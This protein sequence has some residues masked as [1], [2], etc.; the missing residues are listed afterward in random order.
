MTKLG[1]ELESID[2]TFS[3]VIPQIHKDMIVL[4]TVSRRFKETHYKTG[5]RM[6]VYISRK[7]T[8]A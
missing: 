4:K 7:P 3:T 5:H 6:M 1:I 8:N 2:I